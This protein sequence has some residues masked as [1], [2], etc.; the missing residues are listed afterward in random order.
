M[1]NKLPFDPADAYKLPNTVEGR[2]L[3]ALYGDSEKAAG[4]DV[5]D[6]V[7]ERTALLQSA[8]DTLTANQRPV[9]EFDMRYAMMWAYWKASEA[10]EMEPSL[11]HA[12]ILCAISV[13]ETVLKSHGFMPAEEDLSD[14]D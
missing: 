9:C 8:A 1:R 7:S 14:A 11:E 13:C 3:K 5:A 6:C 2:I 12:L 4:K 10:F